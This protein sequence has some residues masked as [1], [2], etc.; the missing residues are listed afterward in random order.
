M[1]RGRTSHEE[2]TRVALA[3]MINRF[4]GG[5]VI[6]A[7]DVDQLPETWLDVFRG[8]SEDM[9]TMAKAKEKVQR[10]KNAWL[11]RHPTYG[12]N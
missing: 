8:L 9:P 6:A 5:T 11:Q 10:V 3:Q 4:S 7:W 2:L 12:K 1:E